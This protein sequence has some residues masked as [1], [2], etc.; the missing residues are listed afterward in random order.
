MSDFENPV[1]RRAAR[2]LATTYGAAMARSVVADLEAEHLLA[3][4]SEQVPGP[5]PLYVQRTG[6]GGARL[7][8]APLVAAL[9]GTLVELVAA[10]PEGL[11]YE[12]TELHEASGP[13][14]DALMEGLL[15]RLGGAEL[16]LTGQSARHLAERLLAAVGPAFP[17]QQDRRAA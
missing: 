13:E 14:R 11:V 2:R 8:V 17:R 7:D 5:F 1:A 10:D 15:K 4:P 9:I 12:L 6:T 3:A 16:G